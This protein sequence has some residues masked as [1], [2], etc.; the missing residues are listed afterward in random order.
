VVTC[1][2][3]GWQYDVTNGKVVQTRLR[4]WIAINAEVR[5]EDIFIDLDK[6]GEEGLICEAPGLQSVQNNILESVSG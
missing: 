3:H 4:Q 6:V 5:G 1:P 2:W